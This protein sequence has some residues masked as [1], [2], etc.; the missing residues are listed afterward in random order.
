M[1]WSISSNIM[2]IKQSK[3]WTEVKRSD[4]G[5]QRKGEM[6]NVYVTA[7]MSL[8]RTTPRAVLGTWHPNR[9]KSDGHLDEV[10]TTK[11]A[12]VTAIYLA[13]AIEQSSTSPSGLLGCMNDGLSFS[14]YRYHLMYDPTYIFWR[15]SKR[16]NCISHSIGS[17]VFIVKTT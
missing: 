8:L 9:T 14:I 7:Y 1:I 17:K 2:S 13:M 6:P 12:S 5:R 4:G 11:V 16:F 3:W 15:Y 10:V